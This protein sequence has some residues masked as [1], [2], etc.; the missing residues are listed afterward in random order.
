[1]E[2]KQTNPMGKVFTPLTIINRADESAAARGFISPS[3]IRSVTLPKVL[4][5]TGATT[6][7]LPANIVGRTGIQALGQTTHC[8]L[9]ESLINKVT[10]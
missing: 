7:C 2:K 1:M 4:V 8:L 5:D 10:G 3:E 9:G 6:L